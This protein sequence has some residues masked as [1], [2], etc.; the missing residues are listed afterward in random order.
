VAPESAIHS[1]LTGGVRPM[2]LNERARAAWSQPATPGGVPE[3]GTHGAVSMATGG[4]VSA[5]GAW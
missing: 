2:V 3:G 5:P 1:G 4:R